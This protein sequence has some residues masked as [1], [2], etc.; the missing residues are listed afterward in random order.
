M[1]RG[2]NVGLTEQGITNHG[3]WAMLH[4]ERMVKNGPSTGEIGPRIALSQLHGYGYSWETATLRLTAVMMETGVF[5]HRLHYLSG[6]T[7]AEHIGSHSA[8]TRCNARKVHRP[9]ST[10]RYTSVYMMMHR[11]L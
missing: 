10:K 8:L 11:E 5:A 6:V 7:A 9:Q 4:R 1:K 3:G 2:T